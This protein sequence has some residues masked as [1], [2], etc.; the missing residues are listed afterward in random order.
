MGE[1]Y[2]VESCCLYESDRCF[3]PD[4]RSRC[5]RTRE[6]A[7]AVATLWGHDRFARRGARYRVKRYVV[8]GGEDA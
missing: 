2:V 5:Y 8:A 7:Q 4:P 6:R 1:C 3:A